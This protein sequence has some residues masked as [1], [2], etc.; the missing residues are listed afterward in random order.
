[1]NGRQS[2]Y[3]KGVSA[4]VSQ[5]LT[6]STLR[7]T[8]DNM[9]QVF[10]VLFQALQLPDY[11]LNWGGP[12][13]NPLIL[14]LFVIGFALVLARFWQRHNL[15]LILSFVICFFPAPILS[16]YTVPRVFYI[17]LPPIFIFAGVSAAAVSTVVLSVTQTRALNTRIGAAGL[18]TV[19]F[20]IVASDVY[21]YTN[22]LE[23][24]VDWL[25]RRSFVNTVKGSVQTAPLTLLP[26]TR[27]QDDF[28]WGNTG[29]LKFIAFTALK[30]ENAD[31]RV[32][33]VDY[34]ELP[35]VLNTL[36]GQYD[37][38]SILYDRETGGNHPIAAQTIETI[39]RCYDNVR[40]RTGSFFIT[41]TL[42]QKDLN[43]PK[44]YSLSDLVGQTPSSDQVV[45]ANQPIM[46]QWEASSDRPT[47]HRI[48]VEKRNPKLVWIEAESFPLANGWMFEAKSDHYP[49]FSGTGY[50]LDDVRSGETQVM[51]DVP[52][53]GK[54][55]VWVRSLRS[56][57]EGHRSFVSVG[58]QKF[59]F[60]RADEVEL[61]QWNWEM[62]GQVD[63]QKGASPVTLSREYGNEG[64]KPVLI[65]AVFLSAD[66]KFN[67]ENN[68]L[69]MQVVD[70][71]Q[72]NSTDTEYV[73]ESGLEP[74][75]YRWR[76]QLLDGDQ[77]VDA[78]GRKGVWSDKIEFHVQ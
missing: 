20:L 15:L 23:N 54:Y 51:A 69:W 65:D 25:K 27:T 41:Y 12:L 43:N 11:A 30:D 48:Q 72:V 28:V 78:R 10:T 4:G 76:V 58:D 5:L 66:P 40:S 14:I 42:Q 46:F 26:V 64:W 33:V 53:D 74:G 7:P 60:A 56:T 8:L 37:H 61:M 22:G 9:W 77:L 1:V 38:V 39:Q 70:T 35:G 75:T 19:L 52:Q 32:R 50:I 44:C 55:K 24:Q 68:A 29:P 13:V 31:K 6:E 62:V 73:L 45:P 17:G 16:G 47:A 67:P 18:A 57:R 34:A 49:G 36:E 71:G 59:E 21:I 63:L 2:T 3:V